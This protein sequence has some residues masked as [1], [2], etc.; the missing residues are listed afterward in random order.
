M[1]R[2]ATAACLLAVGLGLTV[3]ATGEVKPTRSNLTT[4]RNPIALPER[5]T[6]GHETWLERVNGRTVRS[7]TPSLAAI[8]ACAI[9][10]KK[11]ISTTRAERSCSDS[12]LVSAS[13]SS[14]MSTP[15]TNSTS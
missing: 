14:S 10:P 6:P 12:S 4:A 9:P 5:V 3:S 13:S 7:V 1:K 15:S 11:R 2:I 8:S